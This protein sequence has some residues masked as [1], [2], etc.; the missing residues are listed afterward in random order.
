MGPVSTEEQSTS[1]IHIHIDSEKRPN[2]LPASK[3][4]RSPESQDSE[5]KDSEQISLEPTQSQQT[6]GES[7]DNNERTCKNEIVIA[8]NEP[9]PPVKR[10]KQSVVLDT[11]S[12]EEESVLLNGP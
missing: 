6:V 4:T 5:C 10:E 11:H 8:V 7:I 1:S 2:V 9:S 12:V 3:D